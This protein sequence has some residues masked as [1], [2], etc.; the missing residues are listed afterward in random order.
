[1]IRITRLNHTPL[2]LNSDLIEHIEMTPDTVIALTSGQKYMV[3]ET[4]EEIIER[5]V[6]FRQSLLR[7]QPAH[8][9][10]IS[11][12]NPAASIAMGEPRSNG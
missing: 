1:M 4:T 9:T 5:V 6:S 8:S 11:S 10:F 12:A 3:L 2:I 7:N